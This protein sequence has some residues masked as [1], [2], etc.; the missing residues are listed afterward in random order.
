MV[1]IS[2]LFDPAA[3]RAIGELAGT[4]CELSVLHVLADDELDPPLEGDLRLVD[5]ENGAVVDITADL[6]TLDAYRGRL[7]AWQEELAGICRRRGAAY[8]PVS[9]S[10]ALADLVFAELRRRRV[11]A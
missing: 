7:G 4:R 1:L 5:R 8:V 3:D 6:G 9:S 10:L 2:D 11:V